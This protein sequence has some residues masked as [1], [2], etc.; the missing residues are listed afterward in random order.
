MREWV[1]CD[2]CDK[3][4]QKGSGHLCWCADCSKKHPMCNPCYVEGIKKGTIKATPKNKM[5][6]NKKTL[7]DLQ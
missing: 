7:K 6:Y 4:F 3:E 2:F 1:L 5:N